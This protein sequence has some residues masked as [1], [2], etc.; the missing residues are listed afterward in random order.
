VKRENLFGDDSGEVQETSKKL[1]EL[2]LPSLME[3][4]HTEPSKYII[5]DI[6]II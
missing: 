3:R 5:I 4:W 2:G 1:N 6:R